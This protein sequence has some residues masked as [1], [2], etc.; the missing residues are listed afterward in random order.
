MR[1]SS[2]TENICTVVMSLLVTWPS[3]LVP[4]SNI[5]A[6]PW[7]HQ[8]VL[9]L[10][11]WNSKPPFSICI[12]LW[13]FLI[14]T[15]LAMHGHV[16]D[17]IWLLVLIFWHPI[18]PPDCVILPTMSIHCEIRVQVILRIIY[19]MWIQIVRPKMSGDDWYPEWPKWRSPSGHNLFCGRPAQITYDSFHVTG[20]N[21]MLCWP[22]LARSQISE[23]I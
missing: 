16:L 18:N 21:L 9:C 17:Y 1:C 3:V 23:H 20:G 5:D 8:C 19:P 7:P 11:E 12:S 4:V 14:K 2:V 22:M 6:A 13:W 15:Q 10:S